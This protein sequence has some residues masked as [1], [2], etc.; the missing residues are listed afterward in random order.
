VRLFEIASQNPN[1]VVAYDGHT[2]NVTDIGF[3]KDS[4][5][6]F[7]GSEDGSIKVKE[8]PRNCY[9][10]LLYEQSV[11]QETSIMDSNKCEQHF[12]FAGLYLRG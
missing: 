11:L 4:K 5:W 8:K 3:Q 1:P 2:T 9:L 10:N 6:M 12:K 7:T